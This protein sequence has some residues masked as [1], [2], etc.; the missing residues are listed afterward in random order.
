MI[1]KLETLAIKSV[2]LKDSEYFYRRVCRYYS[3]NF[4]TPLI[5]V[6]DLPWTFVFTNYLEHIIETNNSQA[7]VYELAIDICYPEKKVT[8]EDEINKRIKE[9]EAEEAAKR[10]K[11]KKAKE[12]ALKKEEEVIEIDN[13]SFS[14]L[15][16]EMEEDD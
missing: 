12:E 8:E 16:E 3:A 11:V 9:I 10:E 6:Y 4:H 1:D 13:T 14:H 2:A 5:E 7:D 15:E